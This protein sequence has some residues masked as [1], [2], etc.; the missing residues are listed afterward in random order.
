MCQVHC[1]SD[2]LERARSKCY[3]SPQAT[4]DDIERYVIC[5]PRSLLGLSRI[6]HLVTFC[7]ERLVTRYP[8]TLRCFV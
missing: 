6:P 1:Q 4:L 2:N 8:F 3:T 7:Y 5:S